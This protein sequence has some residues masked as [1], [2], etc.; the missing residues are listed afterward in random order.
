MYSVIEFFTP[1]AGCDG[2][3][4]Q[5]IGFVVSDVRIQISLWYLPTWADVSGARLFHHELPP[6]VESVRRTLKLFR[7]ADLGFKMPTAK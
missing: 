4:G 1:S 2:K 3:C 7:L 5:T 6:G